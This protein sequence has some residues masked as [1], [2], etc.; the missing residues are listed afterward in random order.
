MNTKIDVIEL[1]INKSH[2]GIRLE[3]EIIG[4][5]DFRLIS[6]ISNTPDP[7]YRELRLSI[8]SAKRNNA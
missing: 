2:Q 4:Q 7:T 6:E 5:S 1:K 8:D 3:S